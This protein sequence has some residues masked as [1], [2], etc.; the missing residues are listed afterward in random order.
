[1]EVEIS[2]FAGP[3]GVS[4]CPPDSQLTDRPTENLLF[5]TL[6]KGCKVFIKNLLGLKKVS[7][8]T[9]KNDDLNAKVLGITGDL[10]NELHYIFKERY[11]DE[12]DVLDKKDIKKFN[13]TK[14]RLTADY[15]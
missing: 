10:F 11:K 2:N 13:Y 6:I 14:L 12:K 8:Q 4:K 1:M 7:P 15:Q 9:K 3:T 5:A